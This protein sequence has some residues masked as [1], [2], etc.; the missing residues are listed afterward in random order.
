MPVS[1]ANS[2]KNDLRNYGNPVFPAFLMVGHDCTVSKES[3][4]L[5]FVR[6]FVRSIETVG[7]ACESQHAGSRPRKERMERGQKNSVPELVNNAITP[8]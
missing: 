7:C 1:R 3:K 8:Q 5:A 4:D 2:V 6:S